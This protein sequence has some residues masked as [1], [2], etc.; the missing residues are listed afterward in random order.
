[1]LTGLRGKDVILTFIESYGRGAVEDPALAPG[2]DAVLDAGTKRL[3]AA[4]FAARSGFLTSPTAGGGSWLAH[5]TL[6]SGLWID[7]QQRHDTLVASDRFTLTAAFRR[8]NWRTV[9]VMPGTNRG[10]S[11]G[12][13]YGYD[14]VYATNDLGYRGPNFSWAPMPD[15]YALSAFQRAELARLDHAPVMTEMVLVSSHAPGRR[16]PA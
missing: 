5:S 3:R 9:A 1:L 4:G 14:K 12:A 7:N 15:Q 16:S 8:A 11:D 10:W 2:V 6:L 13:F